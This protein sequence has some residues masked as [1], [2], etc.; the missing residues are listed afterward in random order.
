MTHDAG[1]VL[2]I[3]CGG[4]AF[5][6]R[7]AECSASYTRITGVDIKAA[8][9]KGFMEALGGNAEF[10]ASPVRDYLA[11]AGAFD[12]ISVSNALHHLED[13]GEIV[14][15]L[16]GH[17]NEGGTVIINEM[18]RDGL[19]PPQLTQ[20]QQ[21]RFLADLHRAAGEYHRETWSRP[22]IFAFV[23]AAGLSVLHVFEDRNE[24]A[25]VSRG[26][27]R[28]IERARAA[29]ERA[30]PDG[31]PAA[32]GAELEELDRRGAEIGSA[33]P[34]QLTLVCVVA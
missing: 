28:L 32:V 23:E 31:A 12:T 19:T 1:A 30:Y 14:K 27:G 15:A 20:H 5:T 34:P 6:A 13:V 17:L 9:E 29:V 21:H 8:A 26:S 33:P 18:H 11:N 24:A 16:P 7:I 3:A 25:E 10:I 4:G 22:E 2:D